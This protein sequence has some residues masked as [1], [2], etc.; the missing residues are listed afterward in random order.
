MA[1]RAT[2]AA[3]CCRISMLNLHSNKGETM[4][5]IP[6]ITRAQLALVEAL[7]AKP[8]RLCEA[9]RRLAKSLT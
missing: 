9:R 3:Y 6:A 4:A 5:L 8:E 2:R 7:G 1:G